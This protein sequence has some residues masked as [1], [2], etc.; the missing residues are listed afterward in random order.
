MSSSELFTRAG[1]ADSGVEGQNYE[2]AVTENISGHQ[3]WHV[4]QGK[5]LLLTILICLS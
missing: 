5:N 1:S 2:V 4:P 3:T